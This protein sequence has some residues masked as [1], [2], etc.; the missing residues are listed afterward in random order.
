MLYRR[1]TAHESSHR[2]SNGETS[3]LRRG[4]GAAAA[5]LAPAGP[6]VRDARDASGGRRQRANEP[7]QASDTRL[8]GGLRLASVRLV[9]YTPLA[10]KR[11]AP[12]V[13]AA[14]LGY[15]SLTSIRYIAPLQR[16]RVTT[17]AS[18]AACAVAA[19][20]AKSR[21][22]LCWLCRNNSAPRSRRNNS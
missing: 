15:C 2:T 8:N 5:E 22:L 4:L 11:R 21:R 17:K 18:I 9:S 10:R 6:T 12:V 7:S 3:G 16:P 19:A 20:L 14:V 1:L 13:F